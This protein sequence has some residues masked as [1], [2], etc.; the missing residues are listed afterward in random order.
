[1][2]KLI[3]GNTNIT[4]VSVQDFTLEVGKSYKKLKNYTERKIIRKEKF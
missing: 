4:K 3:L 1:M 2:E